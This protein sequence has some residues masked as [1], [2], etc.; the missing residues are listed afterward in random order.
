M[1]QKQKQRSNKYNCTCN[2]AFRLILVKKKTK[3]ITLGREQ[4]TQGTY[5]SN[6]SKMLSETGQNWLMIDQFGSALDKLNNQPTNLQQHQ[7]NIQTACM[8]VFID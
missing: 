4:K 5:S 2:D 3:V 7:Q 1:L 6:P 8:F